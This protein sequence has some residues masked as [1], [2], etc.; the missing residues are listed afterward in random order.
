M[1]E[2]KTYDTILQ[3]CL[4]RVDDTFDKREGSV[5]FDALSPSCFELS[6]MYLAIGEVWT[7][8]NPQTAS[9][10]YLILKCIERGIT[11]YAATYAQGTGQFDIEVPIG[12]RFSGGSY[13]WTVLETISGTTYEYTLECE[14]AGSAPN[15][16]APTNLI[17]IQ[18][19]QNLKVAAL[20]EITIPGEDEED[21]EHLR[22]RY[23][24]SFFNK[25]YRF[26]KAQII[27]VVEQ[28]DGV[29]QVK[30]YRATPQPG[31]ITCYITGAGQI[32]PT[33]ELVTSVQNAMDPGENGSG[34]GLAGMD[35]TFHILAASG[36]TVDISATF[37]IETGFTFDGLL[38]ALKAAVQAYF[39][40]L[41]K[42]WESKE[43]LIVR[44][45]QIEAALVNVDG[46]TDVSSLTING[47][48]TNISL[49]PNAIAV[50][51]GIT[52]A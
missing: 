42:T 2:I 26:N 3:E 4:G 10:E 23:M 5:I 21:T 9:R 39:D 33:P 18:N 40:D 11:P 27:E 47:G 44:I 51:G 17:P 24:D 12:S 48:T 46:V 19:I 7:E 6:K 13:N 38:P 25:G 1:F 45:S 43:Y 36:L 32:V 30:P 50:L 28:I 34:L 8:S 15:S 14:T 41:N 52:N 37:S 20:T 22:Q 31:D 49:D 35:Q 29:G 16:A